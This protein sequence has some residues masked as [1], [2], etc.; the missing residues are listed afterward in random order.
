[1]DFTMVD[2][3]DDVDGEEL[4]TIKTISLSGAA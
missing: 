4:V 1:M 2:D 3:I